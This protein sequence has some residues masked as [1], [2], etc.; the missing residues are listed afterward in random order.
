VVLS[1]AVVVAL[2][3]AAATWQL[4]HSAPAQVAVAGP[5][6]P[7][8]SA[9]P[10]HAGEPDSRRHAGKR[11]STQTR[12]APTVT[13]RKRVVAAHGTV[14]VFTSVW[15]EGESTVALRVPRQTAVPGMSQLRV[16]R[17]TGAQ[18]HPFTGTL[19]LRPG[20][21]LRLRSS[22][23]WTGCPA[24]APR[25]WP[26]PIAVPDAVQVRWQRVDEPLHRRRALCH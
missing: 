9:T 4:G 5:T 25:A 8:A 15:V 6:S 12:S 23:L 18:M 7:N 14:T 3:G 19:A 20:T 21:V 1:A 2:A 22:Y 10:S 13:G 24:R 11:A 16:E 26:Q 17:V